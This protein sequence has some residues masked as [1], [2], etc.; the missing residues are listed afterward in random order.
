MFRLGEKMGIP[1]YWR[2]ESWFLTFRRWCLGTLFWE[3][4]IWWAQNIASTKSKRKDYLH[5]SR[6]QLHYSGKN[7]RSRILKQKIW[8]FNESFLA[9]KRSKTICLEVG[10]RSSSFDRTKSFGC[11]IPLSIGRNLCYS[12]SFWLRKNMYFLSYC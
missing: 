4:F 2:I 8:I 6:R 12:W 7:C 5:G 3:Q 11:F 1:S 10:R 9:R